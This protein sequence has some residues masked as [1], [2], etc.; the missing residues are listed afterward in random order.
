VPVDEQ[1]SV[2]PAAPQGKRSP[3]EDA[4][5]SAEHDREL[6]AVDDRADGISEPVREVAQTA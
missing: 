4:A 1:Q 6:T 2:A 5:V 3:E